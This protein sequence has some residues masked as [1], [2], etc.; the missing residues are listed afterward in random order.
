MPSDGYLVAVGACPRAGFLKAISSPN[1]PYFSI[2]IPERSG[3]PSAV[4]GVGLE[5][6]EGS[7]GGAYCFVFFVCAAAGLDPFQANMT[8]ATAVTDLRKKYGFMIALLW[9]FRFLASVGIA[10][11]RPNRYDSAIRQREIHRPH[12][13]RT[14]LREAA[15]NRDGGAHQRLHGL[16]GDPAPAQVARRQTFNRPTGNLATP[17]LHIHEPVYVR[18]IP[19]DFC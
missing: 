9:R 11:P 7:A 1:S 10:L 14:V 13:L 18:I 15:M 17:I 19:F 4:R 2:H 5:G 3:C 16:P 8:N 12:Q 6:P